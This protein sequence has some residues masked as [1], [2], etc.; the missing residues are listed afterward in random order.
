MSPLLTMAFVAGMVAP[1]NPCGFALLPAWITQALGDTHARPA[2][3]PI[4]LLRA[5][6]A[7]TALTL[8]FAGTLAAAGLLVSAGARG[9]IQAAPALGFAVGIVLILIGAAM[10]AGRTLSLRLPRIRGRAPAGRTLTGM[11]LFGAG[12]AVAS[13]SCT[14]GVLLAVIAQAQATAHVTGLLLV[15]GVYA[16]GSATILLL[17]AVITGL[18]GT[19]LTRHAGTMARY[20]PRATA[21][22]LLVTGA[23]LAWYWYPALTGDPVSTGGLTRLSATATS[24]IQAHSTPLALAAGLAILTAVTAAVLTARRSHHQ[25]QQ[26]QVASPATADTDRAV[27][28]PADTDSHCC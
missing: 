26:T 2:P 15:F 24:W 7:G 27:S 10:L 28:V 23:Y 8:G 9:I 11:M 1:V 16:A 25:Q 21:L 6:R 19:V 13:L 18:A 20:G 5:L 3:P 12:Y 14:F 4:R 17:L 22:V